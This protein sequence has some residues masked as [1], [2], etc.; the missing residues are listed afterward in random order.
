M[1]LSDESLPDLKVV[2]IQGLVVVVHQ[3]IVEL[4]LRLRRHVEDCGFPLRRR[5]HVDGVDDT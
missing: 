5:L 3:L 4:A 1:T 2:V